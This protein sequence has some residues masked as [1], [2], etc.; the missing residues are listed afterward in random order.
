[1]SL[2]A[3][4]G[5]KKKFVRAGREFLAVGGIDFSLEKGEFVHIV[6][7]SG[8][9]KSTFLAMLSG[10]LKP[11]GGNVYFE[12]KDIFEYNDEEISAYRNRLLGVIPQFVSM[13]PNLT[14]LENVLLPRMFTPKSDRS[15]VMTGGLTDGV[16]CKD[17]KVA[18]ERGRILLDMLEILHL[19]KQFPREL[20]G[21]EIR[22]VMIARAMMN[23]PKALL[24][25]EPT[26]DLDK[27]SGAEVMGLFKKLNREGVSLVVVT[28]ELESLKYGTRTLEMEGGLFTS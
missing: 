24:A 21:G 6:G 2:I 11:T 15:S 23:E 4:R 22:R 28:H 13:M 7:R 17:D 16:A 26:S 12:E 27:K 5:L 10:L 18:E 3:T 14:V 8:S 1:M 20:S 9:G 19:E 25:D